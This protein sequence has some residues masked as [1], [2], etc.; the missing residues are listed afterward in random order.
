MAN[1]IQTGISDSFQKQLDELQRSY[2]QLGKI[3]QPLA[4]KHEFKR[5]SD[6]EAAK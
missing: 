2:A 1:L 3:Q 5:V 4:A 6:I